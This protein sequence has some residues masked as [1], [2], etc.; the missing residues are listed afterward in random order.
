MKGFMDM[1]EVACN[2]V[3]GMELDGRT[4]R[5]NEAQPKGEFF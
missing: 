4:L 5:V 3:N 1:Q 2:K